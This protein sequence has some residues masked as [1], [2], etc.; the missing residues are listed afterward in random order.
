MTADHTEDVKAGMMKAGMM[1]D[2]KIR[3]IEWQYK[4]EPWSLQAGVEPISKDF[5]NRVVAPL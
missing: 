2:R 1:K 3:K 4:V 5:T